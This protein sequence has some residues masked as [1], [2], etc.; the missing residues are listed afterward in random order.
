MDALIL[1]AV[2]VVLR[3][4][5]NHEECCT[6]SHKVHKA[7]KEKKPCRLGSLQK[8]AA[9]VSAL[10]H[11]ITSTKS[12]NI[13]VG[14]QRKCILIITAKYFR[15]QDLGEWL[16][17]WYLFTAHPANGIFCHL[18]K[19]LW[20]CPTF[21][22]YICFDWC[23]LKIQMFWDPREI[24]SL[25]F[26]TS[27]NCL[28]LFA[29]LVSYLFPLLLFCFLSAFLFLFFY[30]LLPI[31]FPFSITC[32]PSASFFHSLLPVCFPFL[33]YFLSVSHFLIACFLSASHF[34]C[35]LPLVLLQVHS[36]PFNTTYLI[37]AYFS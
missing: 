16:G 26:P 21:F 30:S 7:Y 1:C 11:E 8:E 29:L 13:W 23:F 15:C 5:R 19:F 6:P 17:V 36:S 32:S 20:L 10:S 3:S 4:V 33:H 31:Y 35:L 2:G 12:V 22:S 27:L 34:S 25:L 37:P 9:A 18:L 28:E 24:T 14:V